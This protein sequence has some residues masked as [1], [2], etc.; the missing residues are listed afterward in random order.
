MEI[1]VQWYKLEC[2]AKILARQ[3][4]LNCARIYKGAEHKGTLSWLECGTTWDFLILPLSLNTNF[5]INLSA[6]FRSFPQC[7][8]PLW[9]KANKRAVLGPYCLC[10]NCNVHFHMCTFLNW[11]EIMLNLQFE[12]KELCVHTLGESELDSVTNRQCWKKQRRMEKRLLKWHYA[13]A[14]FHS[15]HWTVAVSSKHPYDA[16][17]S[18]AALSAVNVATCISNTFK[19]VL[20]WIR[21]DL[22]CCSLYW[23]NVVFILML[24]LS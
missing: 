22:C 13:F 14:I 19:C 16:N 4:Y 7:K 20:I 24:S 18:R 9:W 11:T 10:C 12:L 23:K 5:V 2:Y 17:Q 1:N 15:F 6:Y 8:A 21:H 3:I